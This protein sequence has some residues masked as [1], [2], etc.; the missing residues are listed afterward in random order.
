MD[1]FWS[2]IHRLSFTFRFSSAFLDGKPSVVKG[3]RTSPARERG[4]PR[5]RTGSN[6]SHDEST[7]LT[8]GDSSRNHLTVILHHVP[9]PNAAFLLHLPC[10]PEYSLDYRPGDNAHPSAQRPPFLYTHI[11]QLLSMLACGYEDM[12]PGYGRVV[13][14]GYYMW[15]REEKVGLWRRRS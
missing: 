12:T 7:A 11:A 10:V 2:S 15:C 9:I 4:R 3:R 1:G 8:L 6:R 5:R 14:K 13:E